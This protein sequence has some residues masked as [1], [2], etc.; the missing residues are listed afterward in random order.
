M[1]L[2]QSITLHTNQS[3]TPVIDLLVWKNA[4]GKYGLKESAGRYE[5]EF[6]R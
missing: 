4:V 3:S 2:N 5:V 1:G 6:R